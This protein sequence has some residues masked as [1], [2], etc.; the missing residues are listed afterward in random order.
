MRKLLGTMAIVMFAACA[1]TAVVKPDA[2]VAAA[3]T[4]SASDAACDMH[5][6]KQEEA[7]AGSAG[8]KAFDHKPQIGEKAVCPVAGD[9]FV[10]AAD[11][12]TAE[13]QGK[14][15]AFCC[16]DC[17]PSFTAEPAKYVAGK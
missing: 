2:K 4:A 13:Y 8:T 1:Q 10:V 9:V 6:G 14:W 5:T 12:K 15:Y 11:T 3:P 16:D 7:A 17:G